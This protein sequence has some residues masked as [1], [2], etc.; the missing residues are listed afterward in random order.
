MLLGLNSGAGI[1]QV[2]PHH[3]APVAGL[4]RQQVLPAGQ[5]AKVVVQI[6]EPVLT[7][8][9]VYLEGRVKQVGFGT[10]SAISNYYIF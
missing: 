2:D 6:A 1:G 4:A 10:V 8:L 7:A 5:V 9:Q 3:V